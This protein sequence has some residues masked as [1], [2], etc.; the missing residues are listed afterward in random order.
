MNCVIENI[1]DFN[2]LLSLLVNF[3]ENV[4]FQCNENGLMTQCLANANTCI[5]KLSI[6]KEY[7]NEYTCEKAHTIG[8]NV[9]LLNNI[10]KKTSKEDTLCLT[11]KQDV[12]TMSIKN[13]SNLT[14]YDVKLIDL[15]QD[16]LDIPELNYNF[17][18]TISQVVLKTWK[19]IIDLAGDSMEF[20]PQENDILKLTAD[21]D[22]HKMQRLEKLSFNIF[23]SPKPFRLSTKCIQLVCSMIQFNHDI[24][25]CYENETPIQFLLNMENLKIESYFAPM[26]DMEE[27]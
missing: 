27:D 12:L 2:S 18:C 25:M 14:T 15:E 20:E 9:K 19:N 13:D 7:F 5:L 26:M 22:G 6:N 24:C 8:I 10:L 21:N 17:S 4:K 16:W 23:A 11:T 1:K 3:D